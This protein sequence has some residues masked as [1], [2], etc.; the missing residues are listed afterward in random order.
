MAASAPEPYVCREAQVLSTIDFQARLPRGDRSLPFL[1]ETRSNGLAVCER[2]GRRPS[3]ERIE[4][5]SDLSFSPLAGHF[6]TRLWR[7]CVYFDHLR[8]F[9]RMEKS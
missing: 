9:C 1:A 2:H 7:I 3:R 4:L 5:C 6:R 8:P